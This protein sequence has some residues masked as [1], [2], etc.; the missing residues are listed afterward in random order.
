MSK[1]PERNTCNRSQ[2]LRTRS[3]HTTQQNAWHEL[4]LEITKNQKDETNKTCH[5]LSQVEIHGKQQTKQRTKN[6][7]HRKK[8]H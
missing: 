8:L 3:P 5:L 4:R 6:H 2:F 1:T 7:E